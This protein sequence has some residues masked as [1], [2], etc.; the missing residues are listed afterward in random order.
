[1]LPLFVA[2]FLVAVAVRSTGVLPDAVLHH[3][4]TVTTALLAAAMFA[5]GTGVDVRSLV[6]TGGRAAV[7]GG[8]STVVAAGVA[9]LL[10]ALVPA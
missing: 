5:L 2:G 9:A 7:L 4:E 6:R 1:M 8:A 10:V 3:A